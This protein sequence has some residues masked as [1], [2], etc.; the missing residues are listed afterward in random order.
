MGRTAKAEDEF[1]RFADAIAAAVVIDASSSLTAAAKPLE[2][3]AAAVATAMETTLIDANSNN[4][5][6]AVT[7]RINFVKAGGGRDYEDDND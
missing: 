3:S 1:A 2:P 7:L 4:R 5:E 6:E